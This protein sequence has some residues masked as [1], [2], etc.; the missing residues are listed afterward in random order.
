MAKKS[1]LGLLISNNNLELMELTFLGGE[2]KV[3]GYSYL[4]LAEGVVRSGKVMNAKVLG[5]EIV[6]LMKEAKPRSL[7]GEVVLGLAQSQVFLKVFSIPKFEDKELSE[8]IGWHVES[9]GP[10]LPSEAYSSYEI[11]GKEKGSEVKVLVGAVN[12]A[13]VDGYLEALD[14]AGVKVKV[15]EPLAMAEARLINPKQLLNKSVVSAHMYGSRLSVSILVNGKLWFSKEAIIKEGEEGK[16]RAVVE[17]VVRYFLERKEKGVLGASEIVYSGDVNGIEKLKASLVGF[18]IKAVKAEAGIVLSDVGVIRDVAS[19]MFAPV[20]GLAM[21]G[22]FKQKGLINLLPGWIKDKTQLSILDKLM[23]RVIIGVGLGVWLTVGIWVGGWLMID[24]EKEKLDSQKQALEETL[25]QQKESEL[26]AWGNQFNETIN[27]VELI[28]SSRVS[29]NQVL[30]N[31]S[32]LIPETIKLTSFSFNTVTNKWTLAGVA[33]KR[34]NVL[35]LDKALKESE[36]FKEAR[37]YFSSLDS[38]EGVIFRFSGGEDG[39]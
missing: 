32:S 3:S 23:S 33:D 5:G 29:Y 36:W 2:F 17:E 4:K 34:E 30:T 25:S 14:L 11:L 1:A 18:N 13:V 27:T 8:A 19:V 20:V 9:L 31:L 28:E 15:I 26:M 12:E 7:K 22:G 35:V 39:K 24:N 6:K 16:I 10:L 21:R 38:D 37:L